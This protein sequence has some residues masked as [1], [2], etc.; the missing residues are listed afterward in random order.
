MAHRPM[1]APLHTNCPYVGTTTE[2][3]SDQDRGSA[4]PSPRDRIRGKSEDGCPHSTTKINYV[5]T[6]GQRQASGS[7]SYVAWSSQRPLGLCD[8]ICKGTA[9]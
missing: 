8:A 2:L 5:P 6:H 3:E 9:G 1:G 4:A 7:R